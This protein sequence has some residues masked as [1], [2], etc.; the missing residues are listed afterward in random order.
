LSIG[1]WH[2]TVT[3]MTIATR[4]PLPSDRPLIDLLEAAAPLE[5]GRSTAYTLAQRGDFPVEVL[6]IG[7]RLKVRTADLRRYLGLP[8]EG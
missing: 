5:I 1:L 4:V 3:V 2:D 6:K 8:D 7:G